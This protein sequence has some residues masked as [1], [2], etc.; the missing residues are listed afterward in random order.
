MSTTI[1]NRKQ[2]KDARVYRLDHFFRTGEGGDL[3]IDSAPHYVEGEIGDRAIL[4][5]P[6]STSQLQAQRLQEAAEE[7]LGKK[8]LVVTHNVEF[9]R[10]RRLSPDE[11]AKIIATAESNMR[12]LAEEYYVEEGAE[13]DDNLGDR[14]GAGD[15]RVRDTSDLVG[16]DGRPLRSAGDDGADDE[17]GLEEGQDGPT[18]LE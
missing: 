12:K 14:S 16:P 9:M 6:E 1:R 5:V 7:A 4:S 15:V 3:L 2:R 13:G 10:A 11:A 17:E 8:V 18:R